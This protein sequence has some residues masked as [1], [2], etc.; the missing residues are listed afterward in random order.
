MTNSF[1]KTHCWKETKE[2][3]NVAKNVSPFLLMSAK[4]TGVIFSALVSRFPSLGLTFHTCSYQIVCWSAGICSRDS[5]NSCKIYDIMFSIFR[6]LASDHFE[7]Q[8][9]FQSP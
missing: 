9:T 7:G 3:G 6:G 1:W 4:A 5:L 8:F 2:L